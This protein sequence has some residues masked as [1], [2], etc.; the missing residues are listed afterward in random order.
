MTLCVLTHSAEGFSIDNIAIV[1]IEQLY[2]WPKEQAEAL[3]ARYPQA[4]WVWMQ[5]EAANMGA[6]AQ[7]RDRFAA[8]NARLLSRRE[9][10]SPAIGSMHRF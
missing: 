2:P 4:E 5:E 7:M 1:R 8:V 3:M 6:W 9:G 10:A